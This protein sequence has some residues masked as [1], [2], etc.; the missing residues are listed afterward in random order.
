LITVQ[1]DTIVTI[2]RNTI[3]CGRGQGAYTLNH[4]MWSR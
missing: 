1:K 2:G 4:Q 3:R